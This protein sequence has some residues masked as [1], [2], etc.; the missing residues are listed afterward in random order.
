M[1]RFYLPSLAFKKDELIIRD[2]RMVHQVGKVLRMKPG[3]CVRVFDG[4]NEFEVALKVVKKK[5]LVAEKKEEIQNT[6]EPKLKVSLYQAIPKKLALLELVVQ[7]ATELGVFE[8]YPLITER[9]EHRRPLRLD[10][11]ESIAMEASEQSERLHVPQIHSPVSFLEALKSVD[12]GLMAYAR[13]DQKT[14]QEVLK[15][16]EGTNDLQLFIGPEGGFSPE[17]VKAA[18]AAD[19]ECFGMG[20]RILRTET[21]AIVGLGGIL[22]S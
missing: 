9:T 3:D 22:I 17:E 18:K 14:F 1:H 8:V 10:R 5:E 11:L 13:D 20:P 19:V 12:H 7:K 2:A 21:A 16:F 4:E 6:N 15:K